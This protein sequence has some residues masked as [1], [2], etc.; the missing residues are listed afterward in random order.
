MSS[1]GNVNINHALRGVKVLDFTQI[2]A[3]PLIGMQLGD[4][5]ADS[6]EKAKPRL[7]RRRTT[8]SRSLRNTAVSSM[9]LALQKA[10]GASIVNAAT[11]TPRY[12]APPHLTARS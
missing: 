3:G 10:N 2:G 12:Q 5:G 4:I 7:A 1:T 6:S 11:T 8:T 9:V